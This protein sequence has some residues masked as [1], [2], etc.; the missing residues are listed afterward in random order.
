MKFNQKNGGEK[1]VHVTRDGEKDE[2][3]RSLVV[4]KKII[5]VPSSCRS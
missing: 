1:K 2:P 4:A 5:L 3:A